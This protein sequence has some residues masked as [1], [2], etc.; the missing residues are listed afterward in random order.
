MLRMTVIGMLCVRTVKTVPYAKTA[1]CTTVG[2]RFACSAS[3]CLP[4]DAPPKPVDF[5]IL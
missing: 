4:Y 3:A 1:I 5:F 2:N